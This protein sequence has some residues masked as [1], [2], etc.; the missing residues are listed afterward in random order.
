M[1]PEVQTYVIYDIQDD[2]VR[3]RIAN[4][5]KDYGLERIQFSAFT[6]PLNANKREELFLRLCRELGE[7]AGKVM[8]LPVCEKDEK[9]K[10]ERIIHEEP[11]ALASEGLA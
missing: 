11:K 1:R 4:A 9:A 7:H 10:R 3:Y 2:R 6:G 8:V 5:C